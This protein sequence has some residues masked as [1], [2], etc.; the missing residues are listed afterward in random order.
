M[1]VLDRGHEVPLGGVHQRAVLGFFLLHPNEV[2]ATRKLIA[3]LWGGSAP[4]TSRKMIQNAVSKIRVVLASERCSKEPVELITRPPGYMLRIAPHRIDLNI[5]RPLALQGRKQLAAGQYAEAS[6]MLRE[7][8]ALWHGGALMDLAE[9]G[10]DWPELAKLESAR[11]DVLEDCAEAELQ[12]GRHHDLVQEL[13]AAA[14]VEP[15]RERL[16][17][18]LMLAL[19]RC[20]RQL[21]ALAAYRRT[22]DH[23]VDSFGVDPGE[24]LR[25]LERAILNQD[26]ALAPPDR[27]GD[28][29]PAMTLSRH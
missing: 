21:E 2:I 8:L 14:E 29:V 5:F 12:L 11:L 25:R 22:R 18:Q 15:T 1:E 9:S 13:T 3:A 16:C 6:R 10:F 19:Y 26:P 7:A 4:A 24:S 20:D 17:G 23:L 27:E 28:S